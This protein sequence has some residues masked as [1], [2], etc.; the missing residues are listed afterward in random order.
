MIRSAAMAVGLTLIAAATAQ[1]K[2]P[3]WVLRDADTT[4]TLFGSMHA[5]PK[6]ADWNSPSLEAAIAGADEAWFEFPAPAAPGVSEQY[7][8][9]YGALP[10]TTAKTSTLL[11][12]TAR[13]KAV[14][15][16]GSVE[17]VDA[18]TPAA[19]TQELSRRYWA[20]LGVEPGHG[21]ETQIQRRIAP[22]KLRAFGTPA[23]HL[24]LG[25]GAPLE[26]QVRELEG[27]LLAPPDAAPLRRSMEIWLA[28]DV[29]ALDRETTE[30]L[31]NPSAAAYER[32][33]AAR[34]R[35]WAERI[36]AM[37]QKPGRVLV[38]V[39][40][41]HMTGPDGLPAL[42]RAKGLTVEGP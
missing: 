3:V 35:D 40:A 6:D 31:R 39:G 19:L 30:R 10:K 12:E 22:E 36:A 5:L 11:S 29:A 27:Y 42:L 24:A 34:N 7:A 14:A 21:V 8:A 13:A 23:E 18:A 2:P 9:A 16:F 1:A 38:V 33:V 4:I 20:T 37:L 25:P 15:V 28:G 32:I 17:A 41:G 26:E